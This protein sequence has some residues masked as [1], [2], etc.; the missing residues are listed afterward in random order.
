VGMAGQVPA[1]SDRA[2]IFEGNAK[3]LLK[4]LKL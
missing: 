4:L 3:K 2:L 1:N